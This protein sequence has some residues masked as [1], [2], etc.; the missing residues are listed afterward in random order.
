[1]G[2]QNFKGVTTSNQNMQ[3]RMLLVSK[4]HSGPLEMIKLHHMK[5]W[6]YF[7]VAVKSAS[8]L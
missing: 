5:S 2:L 7:I 1:M 6:H 8:S 3:I 4:G